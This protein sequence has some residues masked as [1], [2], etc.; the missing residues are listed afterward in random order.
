MV[1]FY[2]LFE[3]MED[4]L[5]KARKPLY[6]QAY[7]LEPSLSR[8]KRVGFATMALSGQDEECMR[9]MADV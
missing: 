1:S 7:E 3:A 5:K 4:K 2:V 6:V 9:I 8:H